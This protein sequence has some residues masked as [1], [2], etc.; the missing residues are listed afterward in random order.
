MLAGSV[1]TADGQRRPQ[2]SAL[3]FRPF[4]INRVDSARFAYASQ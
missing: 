2:A 1:A 3:A 4:S